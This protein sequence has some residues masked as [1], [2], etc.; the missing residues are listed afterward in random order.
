MRC[1][2]DTCRGNESLSFGDGQPSSVGINTPARVGRRRRK[3]AF[4]R[5]RFWHE[6]CFYV[7][8]TRS[9]RGFCA[10]EIALA[11]VRVVAVQVRRWWL[12]HPPLPVISRLL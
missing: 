5:T 9:R 4:L 7:W 11:L 3:R 6:A 12:C 10:R 2:C 1:G 8:W